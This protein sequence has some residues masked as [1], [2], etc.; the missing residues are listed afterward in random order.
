VTAIIHCPWALE[1]LPHLLAPPATQTQ[2]TCSLASPFRPSRALYPAASVQ[3]VQVPT[4]ARMHADCC[5]CVCTRACVHTCSFMRPSLQASNPPLRLPSFTP[6]LSLRRTPPNAPS[7]PRIPTSSPTVSPGPVTTA[8]PTTMTR[9]FLWFVFYLS[10]TARWVRGSI[11]CLRCL[12]NY[13]SGPNT[14]FVFRMY[15]SC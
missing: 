1:A 6:A 8:A 11:G 12:G 10:S 3:V 5:V 15:R 14:L 4:H 9:V 2:R 13:V 7:P